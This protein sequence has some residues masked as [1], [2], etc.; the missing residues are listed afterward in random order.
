MAVVLPEAFKFGHNLAFVLHDLLADYI[1][2]GEQAGL[3]FFEVPLKRPED[4][5]AM[6]GLEGVEFWEWCEANGYR[7]ILDEHSYRNLVFGLLS[8]MCHFI[9]EGLKCS[10]KGKLTVALSNFRKPLQDNLFLLEWLLADWPGFL[11]KFRDGPGHFD[12]SRMDKDVRKAARI[13]TI[14]KAMDKTPMERWIDPAWLYELRYE[15]ASDV[16]FDPLFNKALH[17]VTTVKH[18][19]TERE[20]INFIFCNDD[21]REAIWRH[22]YMLLPVVLMHGLCVVRTLYETFAPGFD[23]H[24]G[25]TDIWLAVGF[26]LWAEE[27]GGKENKNAATGMFNELVDEAAIDC[28]HC[29]VRLDIDQSNLL[30][31][32]ESG[33]VECRACRNA[34]QLVGMEER[35]HA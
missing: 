17:L 26:V 27:V 33:G 14:G 32:W 7:H 28:P 31:F 12:W 3:L 13:E 11:A 25:A 16:G 20:N 24:N 30:S 22:L 2:R 9:Y 18:Y 23:P 6:E 15:K 5:E 8:D 21:D 35:S 10:E 4:A 1:V 19:A 34:I 29:Q